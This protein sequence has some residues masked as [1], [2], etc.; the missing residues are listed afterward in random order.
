MTKIPVAPQPTRL[1]DRTGVRAEGAGACWPRGPRR[2]VPVC[3]GSGAGGAAASAWRGKRVACL[4]LPLD[5][6][7]V[8]FRLAWGRAPRLHGQQSPGLGERLPGEVWAQSPWLPA[9]PL[10][11]LNLLLTAGNREGGEGGRSCCGAWA[12]LSSPSQRVP[13]PLSPSPPPWARGDSHLE[14]GCVFVGS[15]DIRLG[16]KKSL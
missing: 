7:F 8:G 5:L 2:F 3:C 1:Q 11:L 9:A 13:S 6:G 16:F 12:P 4:L 14:A 15:L 10:R